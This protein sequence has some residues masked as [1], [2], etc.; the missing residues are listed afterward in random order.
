[1]DTR[2]DTEVDYIMPFSKGWGTKIENVQFVLKDSNRLKNNRM[3]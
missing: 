3:E 2:P 1:M